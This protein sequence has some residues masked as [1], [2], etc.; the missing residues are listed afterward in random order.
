LSEIFPARLEQGPREH[1]EGDAESTPMMHLRI[2]CEGALSN[3]TSHDLR[4]AE[5]IDVM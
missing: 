1:D 5:K 4:A 3:V 2:T